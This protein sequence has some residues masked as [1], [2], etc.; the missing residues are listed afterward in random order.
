[1]FPPSFD[2]RRADDADEA[3]ALLADLPDA[4]VL[5]GGHDLIPALKA[6]RADVGAV[7]DVS[8]I[9]ELAG[10]REPRN[11]ENG[12]IAVG[13]TTTDAD[14][15][16][17][18]GL[19]DRLPA[20][21]DAL[22]VLGDRQIRNRGTVGGN[23]AAAHPGSD[24]PAPAIVADATVDVRSADGERT[25]PVT[26]LLV[27]DHEVALDDAELVTAVRFEEIEPDAGGAYVKKTHPASGY[28]MVGVAARVRLTDQT[29][30]DPRVAAAGVTDR[31]RRL[32]GVEDALDG[33]AVTPEG[34][35]DPE[36]LREA[37]SDAADDLSAASRRGDAHASAEF[38][39]GILPEYVRRA[40][41]RATARAAG[42]DPDAVA[43]AGGER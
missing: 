8:G 9:D 29:L 17:V 14:L 16:A 20:V 30:S 28:A 13:A 10:V 41:T 22:C 21:A 37:T 6:G 33:V 11:G 34:R 40:V 2:Y 12:V 32:P 43:A 4:A 25:L 19:G 23:L 26:D 7:V 15:L 5:A 42:L 18:E 3:V 35:P 31:A 27:G 36:G 38:R 39:A 24:L 1:M